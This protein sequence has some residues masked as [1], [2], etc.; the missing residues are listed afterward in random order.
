MDSMLLLH[1][2]TVG[3]YDVYRRSYSTTKLSFGIYRT[4]SIP[5]FLLFFDSIIPKKSTNLLGTFSLRY[6]RG[7]L[8]EISPYT[9]ALA[10]FYPLIFYNLHNSLL[11]ATFTVVGIE[12]FLALWCS[13]WHAVPARPNIFLGGVVG[14]TVRDTYGITYVA[15]HA[16]FMK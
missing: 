12:G 14:R 3:H 6:F 16:Y 9:H 15:R 7:T 1:A 11:F 10:S 5:D 4:N 13:H 8:S 2:V